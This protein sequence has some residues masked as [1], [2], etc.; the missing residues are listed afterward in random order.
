[1]RVLPVVIILTMLMSAG[2]E[3]EQRY[4]PGRD[5]I[6]SFGDGRYQVLRLSGDGKVLYDLKTQTEILHSPLSWKKYENRVLVTGKKNMD[7]ISVQIDLRRNQI[8][9]S[10][11]SDIR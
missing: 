10:K 2:C 1:M 4:L 9:M 5:T 7:T 6:K 11:L 3:R 8:N